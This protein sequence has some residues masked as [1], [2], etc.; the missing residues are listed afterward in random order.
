LFTVGLDVAE[1]LTVETLRQD[2]VGFVSLYLVRNVAEAGKV[3]EVRGFGCP[4]KGH[5]EQ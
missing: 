1:L 3:E 5:K 4:W 2:V